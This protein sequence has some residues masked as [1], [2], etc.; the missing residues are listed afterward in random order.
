MEASVRQMVHQV[1]TSVSGSGGGEKGGA[2]FLGLV[3][4]VG[5]GRDEGTEGSVREGDGEEKAE[6]E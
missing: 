1:S 3:V 2:G 6:A 5:R 4:E